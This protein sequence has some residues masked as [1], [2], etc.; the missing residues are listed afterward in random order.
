VAIDVAVLIVAFLA[1]NG[2]VVLTGLWLYDGIA[3]AQLRSPGV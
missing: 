1:L 2:L 3:A